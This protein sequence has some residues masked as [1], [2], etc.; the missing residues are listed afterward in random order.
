MHKKK[1]SY[2]QF[3]QDPNNSNTRKPWYQRAIEMATMW[4]IINFKITKEISTTS[5]PSLWK[6]NSS[7][8]SGIPTT[9][10]NSNSNSNRS[11][12]LR[13]CI[14]LKVATSFSRVCLCAPISSYNEV[15]RAH[16]VLP[17]RSNSYPRSKP[18]PTTSLSQEVRVISNA[19]HSVEGRKIFRGKS[20]TDD[21]L[22]R[23]FVIEEEA[24]MQVRRRNEME[25]I[26]KRSVMRRKK[27]GPSRL[28][29]MVMAEAN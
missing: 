26:R 28:S 1:L 23:Q 25:V 29:R 5:N 20:L 22:M 27:L 10:S 24:M 9:N 21:V 7:K 12:K 15:F 8:S 2:F 11:N 16:E 19:R 3:M 4:K 6:T 18:L 17:R 14:S 13:K